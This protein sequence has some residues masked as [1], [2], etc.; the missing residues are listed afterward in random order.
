LL[1]LIAGRN[2][3]YIRAY[4]FY[5]RNPNAYKRGIAPE[6]MAGTT[7]DFF[8]REELR[9]KQLRLPQ[10][11]KVQCITLDIPANAAYLDVNPLEDEDE[12]QGDQGNSDQQELNFYDAGKNYVSTQY[13]NAILTSTLMRQLEKKLQ[14][15]YKH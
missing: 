14:A 1:S 5:L 3:D 11:R 13:L 10:P 7:L 15:Q 9:G 4:A 12:H 2:S 8:I 6:G